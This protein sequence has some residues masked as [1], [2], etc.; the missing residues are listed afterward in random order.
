MLNGGTYTTAVKRQ[1][2]QDIVRAASA[3]ALDGRD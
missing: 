1:R 2:R 3:A